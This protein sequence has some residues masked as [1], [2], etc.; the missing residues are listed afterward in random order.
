MCVWF[1]LWC[2]LY[3]ITLRKYSSGSPKPSNRS[4]RTVET[5]PF[6]HFTPVP[7]IQFSRHDACGSLLD[8]CSIDLCSISRHGH[9]GSRSS[10]PC[11]RSLVSW[12][13]SIATSSSSPSPWLCTPSATASSPEPTLRQGPRFR[14]SSK[15]LQTLQITTWWAV[16]PF[17]NWFLPP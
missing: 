17:M 1:I 12:S 6:K 2:R 16:F 7:F 15:S 9:H 13:L 8:L 10:A 3:S 14:Y 11:S 4:N 5:E